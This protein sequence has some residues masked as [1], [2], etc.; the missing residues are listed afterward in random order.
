MVGARTSPPIAPCWPDSFTLFEQFGQ[1]KLG[2][3]GKI[4]TRSLTA[5]VMRLVAYT[6]G[7]ARGFFR[8][9]DVSSPLQ[10]DLLLRAALMLAIKGC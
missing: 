8:F 7:T 10:R 2:E 6:T 3:N 4:S 5:T 1:V 9:T